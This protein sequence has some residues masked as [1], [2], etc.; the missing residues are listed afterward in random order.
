LYESNQISD[1]LIVIGDGLLRDTLDLN[2]EHIIYHSFMPQ[3]EI[4]NFMSKAKYF[5]LPSIAEPWGVV[6]HEAAAA[7]LPIITTVN[8]G[9]ASAFV[10][11]GYNG[12]LFEPGNASKLRE[13]LLKMNKKSQNEIQNMG[14][15]SFEL[16]KQINAEMWSD[17]LLNL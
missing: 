17:V 10:K 9:A 6:I 4:L 1:K 15:H 12:F 7:G 2:K 14:R 11:Q 8:C 13:I 5:C 16:S 3:K